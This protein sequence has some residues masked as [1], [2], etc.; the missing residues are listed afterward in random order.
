M[1]PIY[2]V[3]PTPLSGNQE[4]QGIN[5]YVAELRDTLLQAH[6]QARKSLGRSPQYQKKNTMTTE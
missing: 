1:M 4:S 2:T 3:V 6:A 5:D